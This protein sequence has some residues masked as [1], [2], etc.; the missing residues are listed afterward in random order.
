MQWARPP[1][2]RTEGTE[3]GYVTVFYPSAHEVQ[4]AT[5][6]QVV[7]GSELRGIDFRLT[8]APTFRVSGR[9][10]DG[11]SNSPAQNLAVMLLPASR[12]G[13]SMM[14]T[15]NSAPVRSHD[16]QFEIAGVAPGS[17]V[18]VA[19]RMSRAEE[20]MTAQQP[21]QVGSHDIEGVVITLMPPVEVTG[22]VKTDGDQQLP[23]G[24]MRV[25]L[26]ATSGLPV[27]MGGS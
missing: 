9:V 24:N 11:K 20:R 8:K 14:M 2:R 13:M 22:V 25:T 3:L 18:L 1:R 23:L 7:A 19:N 21:V 4:Q 16:G 12:D 6:L 17:Y 15:R 26:E 5:P 27:D 10:V